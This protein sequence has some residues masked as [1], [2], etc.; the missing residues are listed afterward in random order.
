MEACSALPFR[1]LLVASPSGLGGKIIAGRPFEV[2]VVEMWLVTGFENLDAG[3]EQLALQCLPEV[4]DT[5]Y[6]QLALQFL[7]PEVIRPQAKGTPLLVGVLVLRV[8]VTACCP[9]AA[10]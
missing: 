6:K 4:M 7:E 1:N 8:Q 10:W 5:G 3:Y 2:C 9:V